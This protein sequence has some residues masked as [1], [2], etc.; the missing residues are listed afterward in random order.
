MARSPGAVFDRRRWL[1]LAVVTAG[2]ALTSQAAHAAATIT[3]LSRNSGPLN[4]IVSVYGSG[5]GDAQGPSIVTL[6][7]RQIPV[8]AWSASVITVVTAFHPSIVPALD[9][10]HP[11]AV[12]TGRGLEKSNEVPFLLTA[13]PPAPIVGSAVPGR[14][15]QPTIV[16]GLGP[17]VDETH[18]RGFRVTLEGSGFGDR[19]GRGRVEVDLFDFDENDELVFVGTVLATVLA[20]SENSITIFL[21]QDLCFPAA[22]FSVIR[23]NGKSD[24]IIL[25]CQ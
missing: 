12:R 23:E 24:S 19:Q 22:V 4:T 8:I 5:F 18:F 15:D 7:D 1:A 11:L 9:Q 3:G 17:N 13:E 10:A 16:T 21:D 6:A 14:S 2:L 20:W 25:F